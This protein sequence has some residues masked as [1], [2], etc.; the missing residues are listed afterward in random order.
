MKKNIF[1]TLLL[2]IMISI[3]LYSQEKKQS[4]PQS[5]PTAPTNESNKET[6]KKTG[7]IDSSTYGDHIYNEATLEDFETTQY[8]EKNIKYFTKSSE[9]K[10][11][12]K[13]MTQHPAPLKMSK[14]Y[15]GVKLYG[16]RGNAL[17]IIP[18]KKIMIKKF[19]RSISIWIYGKKFAGELSLL[20]KDVNKKNH[21][22]IFGRLNFVGWRKLTI[23]IPNYV[24]QMDKNLNKKNHLK[25][26]N[27]LYK[28]FN[29]S[30]LPIWH[31]FY[32]DDLTAMN[33]EKYQDKQNDDW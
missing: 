28:P 26:L 33:R 5:P 11:G 31:Y 24:A 17:R 29:K 3:P 12:V 2:T 25:V 30:Q 20:L 13:I 10:A 27:I 16:K 21:R 15:L 19:C 4:A 18:A 6:N 23:N 22:L 32:I 8:T 1:I 7:E 9:E 14:K